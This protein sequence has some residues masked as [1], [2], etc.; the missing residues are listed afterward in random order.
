MMEN[1]P[2]YGTAWANRMEMLDP[3][4]D[5]CRQYRM[6]AAGKVVAVGLDWMP[7]PAARFR[8]ARVR[9]LDEYEAQGKTVATVSVYD[10]DGQL[11]PVRDGEGRLLPVRVG[12]GFPYEGYVSFRH[13][14]WPGND[15]VPVEHMIV[16]GYVPPDRGP[17]G[18]AVYDGEGRLISDV[19]G[20]LGLPLNHH[21]SYEV[22]YVER[23]EEI[24]EIPEEPEEPGEPPP[25]DVDVWLPA[26][27]AR[28][29]G[30]LDRLLEKQG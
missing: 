22:V 15:K 4:L 19:V 6:D 29:E 10:K 25:G 3:R 26:V 9:L 11:L 24:P 21:V 28:I 17:L 1:R 7:E 27:L 18:I 12:L 13:V 30:K 23:V 20:G 8:L 2:V 16:N 5:N 14:I